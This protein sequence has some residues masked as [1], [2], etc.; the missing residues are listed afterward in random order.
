MKTDLYP[1][2][3]VAIDPTKLLPSATFKRQ[4]FKVVGSIMLFMLVYLLLVI[5]AIGLAI[6]CCYVGF[7][8]IVNFSNFFAIILGV[9]VIAVGI[10]VIIFLVKF[11]FAVARD[12]NSRRIEIT[13]EE[14]PRLFEFIRRLTEETHTPFPKK[15]YLSPDVNACVFYNSSFWSMFL[16]IRKNLEIGLGLVN[17]INLSEFKAVMA[18]EFGHFSQRSMKLGSFTYNVNRVIHNILYE[19]TGYTAFLQSWGSIHRFLGYF[20]S[21]TA[22]I[23]GAIQWI[24]RG[25]YKFINRNYLG[26]A[27][28]MEFHA[29][30]VS[31]SVSG[32]NNLVSALNRVEVGES[33][34]RTAL[35]EANDRLKDNKI[36]R[37]I[38]SNQLTIFQSVAEDYKLPVREGLPEVSYQFVE[39][40][41]RSR[42]NYKNQWASHPTIGERKNHLENLDI[43]VRPDDTS[44]WH[45]FEGP[46]NLQETL[47]GNLY[48]S[49]ELKQPTEK[50]DAREF[51]E[52]YLARKA[53]F[54][55]PPVYKGFYDD[56]Y[57]DIKEWDLAALSRQPLDKSFQEIF[58]EENGQIQASINGHKGDLEIIRAISE[59][60][61]EVTTFDFD[62]IKYGI[63]D[64]DEIIA[65]LEKDLEE[66]TERQRSL[67]M[68]AFRYFFHRLGDPSA[69]EKF[70]EKYRCFQ[71]S[72]IQ[73]D[74]YTDLVN[75]MLQ[76]I[77]PLYDGG[78]TLTQV[79]EIVD[80]IQ[81]KYE[82]ALKKNYRV[83]I[84]S[85]VFDPVENKI[86]I[87]RLE[88]F[89][90]Q[91]YQYFVQQRFQNR[92]L[93]ELRGLSIDAAN[94]LNRFEFRQYKLLLEDQAAEI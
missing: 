47:T 86:L 75:E 39:S 70:L 31:A 7:M 19:N 74:Q 1:A 72:F 3:P 11:I 77:Q 8:V 38:F 42:I 55:L 34:Y 51:S 36:A 13:E 41:S 23:A 33:C 80:E 35:G 69:R 66:L 18:H 45:L 85:G 12:E 49:V 50:Y 17:C 4:A 2:S 88:N 9:G 56:R 15:I 27:R 37:N 73:Y 59:K 92:E 89:C 62:G 10:S 43:I 84:D 81:E 22:K 82:P 54:A 26:L 61:L 63:K 57:I 94:E 67:D 68:K 28:E 78:L 71:Q 20:A 14:Q 16:P 64:C 83:F 29:D 48:Q 32:G 40:F 65:R 30:S 87:E 5:A 44:V 6:A 76:H 60:K 46:E 79:N 90:K 52:Q 21:I 91:N 93:G 53:S 24:L 58:T 25:M